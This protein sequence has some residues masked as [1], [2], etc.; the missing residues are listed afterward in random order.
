[1][2]YSIGYTRYAGCYWSSEYVSI[3]GII[4]IRNGGSLIRFTAVL[5]VF[6]LLNGAMGQVT[7]RALVRGHLSEG[8]G[9]WKAEDFG[10]F[11]YDLDEGVGGEQLQI[12][13]DDLHIEIGDI[14]YSSRTWSDEFEFDPW[15]SYSSISLFGKRYFAGYPESSFS[16]AVSSIEDGELREILLDDNGMHVLKPESPFFLEDGYKLEIQDVSKEGE[17]VS[18]ILLKD[19]KPVDAAVINVGDTYVYDVGHNDLPIVLVHIASALRGRDYSVVDVDGIFQLRDLASI[20]LTLGERLEK[21]EVMELS[22]TE[23][24]LSN[25]DDFALHR[26]SIIRLVDGLMLRIMDQDFLVYYP[27]GESSDYG[28]YIIRGAVYDEH[29][30]V[31]FSTLV[32]VGG[33]AQAKWNYGDFTGFYFDDTED[34]GTE[35]LILYGTRGRNIM[36]ISQIIVNGTLV[37]E[38]LWYNSFVQPHEFEFEHWGEYYVVSLFGQLWFAGFGQNTSS[39]IGTASMIEND[40]LGEVLLDIEGRYV[41]VA[42]KAFL[43]QKDYEFYIVDVGEEEIFAQLIRNGEVLDSEII[44]SNSTYIYEGDVGDVEDLPLISIHVG[45]VFSNEEDHF[46]IID[47]IFQVADY[48]VPVE[49]GTD[50]GELEVVDANP[51]YVLLGNSETISLKRDSTITLW[52]GMNMAIADNDTLRYYPY[53]TQFVVPPPRIVDMH[54]PEEDVSTSS[55][56]NFDMQILAGEMR[57]VVI[58]IIDSDGRTVFLTEPVGRG[59]GDRWDYSWQWNATA[60]VLSDQGSLLPDAQLDFRA[61]VLYPNESSEPISVAL[62]FNESGKLARIED[63]SGIIYYIARSEYDLTDQNLS[64]DEML[65]DTLRDKY[66]KVEPNI[67]SFRLFTIVNATTILEDS[68]HTLTGSIDALEPHLDRINAPPGRYELFL[69]VE[70][71]VSTLRARG[72]FFNVSEPKLS[73]VSI[74]SGVADIGETV[75]VPLEISRAEEEKYVEIV[76]RPSVIRAIGVSDNIPSYIDNEKGRISI[77]IPGEIESLNVTFQANQIIDTTDLTIANVEGFQPDEVINGSIVV[78]KKVRDT[79]DAEIEKSSASVLAL[80]TALGLAFIFGRRRRP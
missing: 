20:D 36:P 41:A 46:A 18:L 22:E 56:G 6:I 69:S 32:G 28:N 44:K 72:F 3:G 80:M 67:S 2:G 75:T 50:F 8:Y 37:A 54:L 17:E 42:G 40:Q 30:I 38:G 43:L 55:P 16:E 24:E 33:Y 60:I 31:P 12:E 48:F 65:N 53:T 73:M 76:Y 10:W 7:D 57:S 1:M 66:I 58:E 35:T 14:V 29:S 5:C 4:F 49:S 23:I 27:I 74:G 26:D 70:N 52:P 47:G 19:E 64:Y 9:I 79:E 45:S 71:L 62:S 59:S 51:Y 68:N 25:Y 77:I 34:I 11:Y 15:G 63:A 39:D 78:A 13:T 61:G 21:M